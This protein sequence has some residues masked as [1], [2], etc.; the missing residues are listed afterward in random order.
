[1]VFGSRLLAQSYLLSYSGAML[2]LMEAACLKFIG[3]NEGY[4]KM[5]S[6]IEER[7]ARM[8]EDD[9]GRE[10]VER[11]SGAHLDTS[12]LRWGMSQLKS[13]SISLPQFRKSLEDYYMERVSPFLPRAP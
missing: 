8:E 1:M 9:Q 7:L 5:M 3:Q 13:S 4:S 6:R 10:S 12:F 2:G 11:F